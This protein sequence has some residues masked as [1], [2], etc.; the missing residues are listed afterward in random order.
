MH[1]VKVIV[2]NVQISHIDRNRYIDYVILRI[3]WYIYERVYWP[4]GLLVRALWLWSICYRKRDIYQ[5]EWTHRA[6][7]GIMLVITQ[8][9][10]DMVTFHWDGWE[11]GYGSGVGRVE[12]VG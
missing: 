10:T 9:T 7:P 3:Y 4:V 5:G 11:N 8:W 12:R 2:H 1:N 6:V